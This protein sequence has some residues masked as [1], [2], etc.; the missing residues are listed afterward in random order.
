MGET[1]GLGVGLV[2]VDAEFVGVEGGLDA[3][4]GDG[5]ADG[6]LRAGLC[7]GVFEVPSAVVVGRG[8]CGDGAGGVS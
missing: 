2:A 3:L 8:L 5:L 4:D 7:G 6:G 1:Q